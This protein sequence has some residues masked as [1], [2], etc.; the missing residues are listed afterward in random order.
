MHAKYNGTTIT[1][2]N[3]TP[4]VP[5]EQ[6][7][8]NSS[9]PD[10]ELELGAYYYIIENW[11]KEYLASL[12]V[13]SPKEQEEKPGTSVYS[14]TF[15]PE[16][17]LNVPRILVVS[18]P[19]KI[20]YDSS[21]NFEDYSNLI[22]E[23]HH[24]KNFSGMGF[25]C[26]GMAGE[27]YQEAILYYPEDYDFWSFGTNYSSGAVTRLQHSS[28]QKPKKKILSKKIYI[29]I[30]LPNNLF[31]EVK[32]CYFLYIKKNL[33]TGRFDFDSLRGFDMEKFN[34]LNQLNQKEQ[35]LIFANDDEVNYDNDIYP[36][37]HYEDN[38]YPAFPPPAFQVQYSPTI[39]PNPNI[40]TTTTAP[41]TY[42]TQ[43]EKISLWD[44]LKSFCVS[45]K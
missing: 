43:Q 18:Q 31:Y 12:L 44:T 35:K 26:F 27:F 23:I 5:I 9:E 7:L 1:T 38:T 39:S 20:I 28:S 2:I 19:K 37:V 41:P 14:G 45:K 16:H 29:G 17:L 36:L 10:F 15:Y 21:G 24:Q 22:T 34:R 40:T 3:N 42:K 32:F 4:N 30:S 11:Q 33:E 8:F 13:S 25:G 6:P